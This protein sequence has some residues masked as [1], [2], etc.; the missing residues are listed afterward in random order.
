MSALINLLVPAGLDTWRVCSVLGYCL[1]PVL[2]LAAVGVLFS[3]RGL[4]G[5]VLAALTV[6]WATFSSTRL[7]DAKL[8]LRDQYWLVAYPVMLLYSTFVLMTMF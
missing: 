7:F 2:L 3:L 5:C 8:L 1:L 4:F 6:A